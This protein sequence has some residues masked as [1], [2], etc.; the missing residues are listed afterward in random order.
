MLGTT[1]PAASGRTFTSL[2]SKLTAVVA[3]LLFLYHIFMVSNCYE[4]HAFRRS[5]IAQIAVHTCWSKVVA[6]LK[7]FCQQKCVKL[8]QVSVT[9]FKLPI[10]VGTSI[11]QLIIC[12]HPYSQRTS[13]EYPLNL[14]VR[15]ALIH[16]LS[17]LW[18]HLQV[19]VCPKACKHG[20][21]LHLF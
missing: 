19:P 17:A 8:F 21:E 7:L 16:H 6:L 5:M 3:Q 14:W 10:V 11:L 20:F 1:F 18:L 13:L 12:C 9:S 2:I 15:I 4:C